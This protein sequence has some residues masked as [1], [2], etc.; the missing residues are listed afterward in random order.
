M[1]KGGGTDETR[2]PLGNGNSDRRGLRPELSSF[3]G[4]IPTASDHRDGSNGSEVYPSLNRGFF[5]GK[6]TFVKGGDR[7]EVR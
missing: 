3:L 5:C 6:W 7:R 4:R 1:E 2:R